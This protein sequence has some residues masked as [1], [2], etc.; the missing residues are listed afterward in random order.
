[1]DAA[2]PVPGYER[3]TYILRGPKYA[4]MIGDNNKILYGSALAKFY[5]ADAALPPLGFTAGVTDLLKRYKYVKVK[6]INRS[7]YSY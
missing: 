7:C 6:L 3:E 5:Y 2:F 4:R 1:M